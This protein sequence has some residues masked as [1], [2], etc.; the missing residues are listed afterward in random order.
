MNLSVPNYL[1]KA[2]SPNAIT[3]RVKA[4]SCE[5]G[6]H[7]YSVYPSIHKKENNIYKNLNKPSII[8]SPKII[9]LENFS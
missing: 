2:H 5:F 6:G 4:M 3:V 1:P 8:L 9:T 7:R